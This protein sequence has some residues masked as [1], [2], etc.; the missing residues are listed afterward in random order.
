MELQE[1]PIIK[2]AKRERQSIRASGYAIYAIYA[3]HTTHAIAHTSKLPV[4]RSHGAQ[5]SVTPGLH[6]VA[7]RQ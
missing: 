6:H 7:E 4:S 5:C 3:T 2:D 1:R